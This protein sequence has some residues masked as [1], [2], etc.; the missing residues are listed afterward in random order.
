MQDI[1]I[2]FLNYSHVQIECSDS[3]LLEM[4]DYFSFEVE[5][6]RFQKDLSMVDGMGV[7]VF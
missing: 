4:R 5:G 3:I 2:H 7:F 6:A 1:K